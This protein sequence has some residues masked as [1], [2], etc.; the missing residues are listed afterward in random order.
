MIPYAQVS[1]ATGVAVKKEILSCEINLLE[2]TKHTDSY[3]SL[4][5]KELDKKTAL[6]KIL[7]QVIAKV[8]TEIAS[9]P[10]VETK[11]LKS[12]YAPEKDASKKATSKKAKDIEFQLRMIKERLS[13]LT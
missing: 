8:N 7:R 12:E 4:R 5:K 2:M 6:R 11:H 10:V 13:N 1:H 3:N 9:I